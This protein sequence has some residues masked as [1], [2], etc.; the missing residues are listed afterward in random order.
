MALGGH[1]EEFGAQ[2]TGHFLRKF[3]DEILEEG[4]EVRECGLELVLGVGEE[5]FEV[6]ISGGDAIDEVFEDEGKPRNGTV[7]K[8]ILGT[9]Y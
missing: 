3:G 7:R 4:R 8:S 9:E 6:V 2:A 5:G 1:G